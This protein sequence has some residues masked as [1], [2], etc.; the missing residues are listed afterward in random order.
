ME[1]TRRY[2]VIVSTPTWTLSGVNVFTTHLIRGLFRMGISGRVVITKP[3]ENDAN[4]VPVPPDLTA[5]RL[6]VNQYQ[7]WQSRWRV[8]MDYLEATAPS[9]YIPNYDYEYSCVASK[10]SDRVKVVGILH[11]DD[12]VHYDHSTRQGKN[13]NAV[14]AVS[15]A[16]RSNAEQLD[17]SLC[18]KLITIP[19]GVVADGGP[20]ERSVRK[21]SPLRVVYT[22]RLVQEQ[23]RILELPKIARA[24]EE[25]GVP[26]EFHVIGGGEDAC[27]L[28]A[29]SRE[30]TDAG[31]FR[32]HGILSN[33]KTVEMLDSCDVF[34]LTSEFEGLPVSLLE[35]MA[36]GCVPVVTDIDSGI[37]ELLVDGENGFIVP[38][39]DIRTFAARLATLHRDPERRARMS[40]TASSVIRDGGFRVEDMVRRYVKLFDLVVTQ[41]STG[42]YSRA[43]GP[44]EPP[45]MLGSAW[46]CY[47]P[48][49]ARTMLHYFKWAVRAII[50]W[51]TRKR[52]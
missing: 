37:P 42:P 29:S 36:Q 10:L 24:T 32:F 16:I 40:R 52:T 44:I 48:Q 15:E 33:E 13:W 7:S 2:E 49:W 25:L 18:R 1:F 11:S 14:V 27:R 43:H 26:I 5:D 35:A 34:I 45:P 46:K 6:K 30:L 38:M 39:G 17:P 3:Y 9:I 12:P 28:E 20:P 22:G 8:L 19:Y 31:V 4:C 51:I 23:K 41:G 47:V 21:D 50:S